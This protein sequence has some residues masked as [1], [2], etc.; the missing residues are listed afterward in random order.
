MIGLVASMMAMSGPASVRVTASRALGPT[1]RE[2]L[3]G[4]PGLLPAA[5]HRSGDICEAVARSAG[6]GFLRPLVGRMAD[7]FRDGL[8]L[9]GGRP[10][11]LFVELW[12]NS[13]ASHGASYH[14]LRRNVIDAAGVSE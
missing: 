9:G 1:P 11:Y 13:E 10:L 8:T 4:T 7:E 3:P 14:V 2:H 5:V 12:V 6:Q